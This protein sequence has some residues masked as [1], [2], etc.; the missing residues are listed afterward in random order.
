[1]TTF[2]QFLV[3]Q[4]KHD[5][6][7]FLETNYQY[8]M[9][10]QALFNGLIFVYGTDQ[11]I[12]EAWSDWWNTAKDYAKKAWNWANTKQLSLTDIPTAAGN[13]AKGVA[14]GAKQ[15]FKDTN[16]DENIKKIEKLGSQI[17]EFSKGF[18]EKYKIDP[19]TAAVII[20]AGA[21]GGLGAIPVIAIQ[22]A[23]RRTGSWLSNKAF[24]TA[25]QGI[26][27][28]TP[29]QSDQLFQQYYGSDQK[30]KA[31]PLAANQV[32]PLAANQVKKPTVPTGKP[33][34][35][36]AQMPDNSINLGYNLG[37]SMI[38]R[39][40][41][42]SYIMHK[43]PELYMELTAWLKQ[44][45]N[46][47][48]KA[49]GQ[50][51]QN[52]MGG[53]KNYAKD[54]GERG[55]GTATGERVG[56]GI[57]IGAGHFWNLTTVIAKTIANVAKFM[58]NN[59]VKTSKI[60]MAL[61]VGS[62][63]GHY[64]TKAI[65]NFIKKPSHDQLKE[66]SD[67]AKKAG[68]PENE[69]NQIIQSKT[70]TNA[71]LNQSSSPDD[72]PWTDDAASYIPKNKGDYPELWNKDSSGGISWTDKN[73]GSYLQANQDTSYS[74]TGGDFGDAVSAKANAAASL[75]SDIAAN[76]VQQKMSVSSALNNAKREL[77]EKIKNGQ[78]TDS[79]TFQQ[80][81]LDAKIKYHKLLRG[82]S[83][84]INQDLFD[85]NLTKDINILAG[86]NSNWQNLGNSADIA[87]KVITNVG[88]T[89]NIEALD[90][91]SK[92]MNQTYKMMNSNDIPKDY[93]IE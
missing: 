3:E 14:T 52:F 2:S 30:A 7:V 62:M 76:A 39:L 19:V 75:K 50:A 88:G 80:A 37:D 4:Q 67:H 22:F 86:A 69:A 48:K 42:E 38:G 81:I 9:N 61:A 66:L 72:A 12:L 47:G 59:P 10:E 28:M 23:L 77:I 87:K 41:F 31:A 5:A 60:V 15:G 89:P 26:T 11:I 8:A 17:S 24:D 54:V 6:V 34:M 65:N 71:A 40:T 91:A 49:V 13:F 64:T 16:T 90:K 20:T 21:T 51:A 93:G 58:K 35:A 74:G 68:V 43:D 55:L 45:W 70:G 73:A 18:S 53:V 63:I 85:T 27:G 36:N 82:G 83:L 79:E 33:A 92:L 57:G 25:W 32:N 84:G 29:D 78:V 1:M 56:R 44:Q 46:K